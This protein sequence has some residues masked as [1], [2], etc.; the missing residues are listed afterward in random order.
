MAILHVFCSTIP[1]VK[2]IRGD[3][4][5]I[6]FREGVYR[7]D[8]QRDIDFLNGMIRD[9]H[10]HIHLPPEE[11]RVIE[12][13]MLNP[14]VAL[15]ARMRE[16]IMR[17]LEAA[18]ASG[19]PTRELGETKQEPLKPQN[20]LDVAQATIGGVT[21]LQVPSG[22]TMAEKLAAMRAAAAGKNPEKISNTG[23]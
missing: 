4:K 1:Y 10:P 22:Q 11:E 7:T 3:G 15:E 20:S 9:G 8:D 23:A 12:S 21:M 5:E 17:E 6:P 13:E 2:A 19:D 14:L 18:Q 16:K